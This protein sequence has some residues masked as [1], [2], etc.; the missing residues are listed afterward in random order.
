MDRPYIN[1]IFSVLIQILLYSTVAMLSYV[2]IVQN[3]ELS[4]WHSK[5]GGGTGALAAIVLAFNLFGFSISRMDSWL[6]GKSAMF[7]LRKRRIFLSYLYVAGTLAVINFSIFFIVKLL[8]GMDDPFI[9]RRSGLKMIF[10]VWMVEIIVFSLIMINHTTGYIVKFYKEKEQLRESAAK[11]EY[12]ALQEQLKPHFLFNCL[13][14]LISEIEYDPA[15]AVEFTRNLSDVYRYILKRESKS[16]SS[17][18]DEMDFFNSYMFLYKVRT[19]DSLKTVVTIDEGAMECGIPTMTLQLL[20]EN[21]I[22]HNLIDRKHPVTITVAA[23]DG[24]LEFENNVFPKQNVHKE[25]TG[26]KNLAERY[27][28]LGNYHVDI[29]NGSGIFSVKIPLITES[30]HE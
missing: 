18:R 12:R 2:L 28:L 5:S 23:K 20:A 27:A 16:L 29:R 24:L 13:N 26:L 15:N 25:G 3:T 14:T 10:L 17:L 22:K 21:V 19:D 8:S 1:K 4:E 9:I 11:A 30:G 7:Y 6:S